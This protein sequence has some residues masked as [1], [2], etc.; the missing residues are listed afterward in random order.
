MPENKHDQVR[1]I[2]DRRKPEA[3]N[4]VGVVH[5]LTTISLFVGLISTIVYVDR[6]IET[7]T[8]NNN[9][10]RQEISR[11]N[12]NIDKVRIE[13]REEMKSINNKLDRLT[14]KL[15]GQGN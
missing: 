9:Y 3:W 7:N 5:L 8:I 13:I 15:I 10:N 14:E 2:Y 11:L 6:R 4:L 12:E 1:V